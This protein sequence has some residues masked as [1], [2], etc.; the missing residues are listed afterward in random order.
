MTLSL[1][2]CKKVLFPAIMVLLVTSCSL[3]PSRQIVQVEVP[4]RPHKILQTLHT[5]EFELDLPSGMVYLSNADG[6]LLWDEL[7]NQDEVSFLGKN[8]QIQKIG[9][10]PDTFKGVIGAVYDPLSSQL[11]VL[12][13]GQLY[14][15]GISIDNSE[16]VDIFDAGS[17][18]IDLSGLELIEPTGFTSNPANGDLYILDNHPTRILR[19]TF[20][21][22][23]AQNPLVTEELQLSQQLL[24]PFRKPNSTHLRLSIPNPT[25]CLLLTKINRKFTRFR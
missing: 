24:R 18:P 12:K 11:I 6:F 16:S 2:L 9:V 20:S 15:L 13:S 21:T 22:D 7:S 25:V 19:L 10:F 14:F 23:N 3:R 5:S 1:W 4:S 8:G 17:Q